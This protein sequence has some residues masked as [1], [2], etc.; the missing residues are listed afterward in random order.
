MLAQAA[1]EDA[2]EGA[3]DGNIDYSIS[4][5][6]EGLQTL[7]DLAG[8]QHHFTFPDVHETAA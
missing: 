6:E 5:A 1:F 4:R 3:R 8:G 7:R 2:A